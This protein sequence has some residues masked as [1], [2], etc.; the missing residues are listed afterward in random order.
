VVPETRS[1][2]VGTL[3]SRRWGA[4]IPEGR[5]RRLVGYCVDWT[6]QRHHL[7]GA[8]GAALLVRVEQ[9]GWIR[10]GMRGA[11]RALD[12]TKAGQR[13]FAE[14]LGI[15]TAALAASGVA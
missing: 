10:R 13:G 11:L 9:L 14:F 7:A 6:E 2:G 1:D 3:T 12:I 15:D 5:H 8:A 4:V